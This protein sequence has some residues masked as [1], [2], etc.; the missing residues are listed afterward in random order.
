[1]LVEV[2]FYYFCTTIKAL[3]IHNDQI[4]VLHLQYWQWQEKSGLVKAL[5]VNGYAR[6]FICIGN[7]QNKNT[8][9]TITIGNSLC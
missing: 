6:Q 1:M 8:Y 3:H 9:L 5:Q 7:R 2:I 4:C